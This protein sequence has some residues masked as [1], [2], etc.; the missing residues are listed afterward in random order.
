MKIGI[1]QFI[2]ANINKVSI[3]GLLKKKIYQT[4]FKTK[5]ILLKKIKPTN[6]SKILKK[7]W[8]WVKKILQP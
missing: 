4:F 6:L 5:K 8:T 3:N 2:F 7:I 1:P